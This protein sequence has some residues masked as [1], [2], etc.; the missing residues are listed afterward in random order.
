MLLH[1]VTLKCPFRFFDVLL[2]RENVNDEH[3]VSVM[4]KVTVLSIRYCRRL[5]VLM[6]GLKSAQWLLKRQLRPDS[7][8]LRHI[9]L[10]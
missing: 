6:V 4:C 5:A 10:E 7:I 8:L 2:K 1:K 9:R 3:F